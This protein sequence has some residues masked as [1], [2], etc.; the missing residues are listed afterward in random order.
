M[1]EGE[2]A[3]ETPGFRAVKAGTIYLGAVH[4][5]DYQPPTWP[6]PERSQ[7]LAAQAGEQ[8]RRIP[9]QFAVVRPGLQI[10]CLQGLA[11]VRSEASARASRLA[12]RARRWQ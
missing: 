9:G 4:A 8:W 10:R 12:S 1:L 11:A 3:V 6:S 7:Q 5:D 2:V